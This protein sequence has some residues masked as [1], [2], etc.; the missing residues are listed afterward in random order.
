MNRH[1]GIVDPKAQ[2]PLSHAHQQPSSVLQER[3]KP[4]KE[5]VKDTRVT[6]KRSLEG[7]EEHSKKRPSRKKTGKKVADE[8]PP[9][10]AAAAAATSEDAK[11]STASEVEE[12]TAEELSKMSRSERKRHREKKRRNDVNKGFEDLMNLLLEIDPSVRSEAEERSKRGQ[13]KSGTPNA[14]A[15]GSSAP[16]QAEENL[17]SRVDLITKTTEVLRRVHRENE[18]RKSIIEQ[19]LRKTNE[20]QSTDPDGAVTLRSANGGIVMVRSNGMKPP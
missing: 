5:L 16:A 15:A 7:A 2:Q 1:L 20:R 19:L 17:L 12:F 11:K 4:S 9:A 13:F 18:D 3:K 14:A 10:A 8:P 6:M